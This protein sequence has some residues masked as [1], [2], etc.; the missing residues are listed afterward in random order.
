MAALNA[1][2]EERLFDELALVG[3]DLKCHDE[4]LQLKSVGHG[5]DE[6]VMRNAID[7]AIKKLD[8]IKGPEK[9]TEVLYAIERLCWLYQDLTGNP[10]THSNK[11]D[12]L[13]Y[14]QRPGSKAGK[15]VRDSFLL[16]DSD[17][18]ETQLNR[19]LRKFVQVQNEKK[20]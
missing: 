12:H 6:P 20:R 11:G 9:Q 3:S 18:P 16:I 10:V 19:G 2:A 5:T 1:F 14:V 13:K 17:M 7:S 15:F 4:F 8:A